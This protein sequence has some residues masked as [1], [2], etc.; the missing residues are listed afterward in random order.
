[1]WEP[2]NAPGWLLTT[3]KEIKYPQMLISE[4]PVHICTM[5]MLPIGCSWPLIK[6]DGVLRQVHSQ[7]TK[8]FSDEQLD[9]KDSTVTLSK[10]LPPTL[11]SFPLSLS[12]RV[13]PVLLSEDLLGL[14]G[15]PGL[16]P[17]FCSQVGVFSS[18]HAHTSCDWLRAHQPVTL[19]AAAST[20]AWQAEAKRKAFIFLLQMRKSDTWMQWDHSLP[21]CGQTA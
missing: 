16:P 17:H 21:L 2:W 19:S 11:P 9:L 20:E 3:E 18:P 4:I 14:L 15:F 12:L 13:R 8:G 6:Q 7:E 10:T 5:T 1:M